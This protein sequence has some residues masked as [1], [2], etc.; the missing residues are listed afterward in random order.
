MKSVILIG[1]GPSVL[2]TELGEEIDSFDTV[3]RFN[4][5]EIEG[6]EKNVGKKCNI[7]ARR[8]CDDVMLW[9]EQMFE[10]IICFVTYCKWT[11]G[12]VKVATQL[13]GFYKNI[14]VVP[15]HVC[16][17]YGRA[18]GL[19]QPLEEWAS[20]GA[21]ALNYF[22]EKYD[23]ITIHGFDHLNKNKEGKVEHYFKK[24]PKDDRFHS[25]EKERLFTEE[26]IS[27]GKVERLI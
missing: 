17:S 24:P 22:I 2:D 16:A 20:V 26:L 19:N 18:M 5:F 1:N 27:E 12:M 15:T 21:L 8:A 25:G 7:L 9:P 13:R 3:V 11:R 10:E 4:N 14:S 6:F 23:K